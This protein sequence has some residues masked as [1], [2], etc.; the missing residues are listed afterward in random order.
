M[1]LHHGPPPQRLAGLPSWLLGQAALHG[2]RLVG[3]ALAQD[4]VRKHHFRVLVTLDE[5]GSGSQAEIGRRLSIDRSDLHAVLNDLERDGLVRRVRDEHDR[6]RNVVELTAAGA[7]MLKRLAAR[8]DGAQDALLQPL[9]A[10]ERAELRRLL[11]ALDA[12]HAAR[13]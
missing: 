13:P 5:D 3:Q 1:D 10:D 9:D 6:R 7:A 8:V 12:H 11:A 4:G 2:D